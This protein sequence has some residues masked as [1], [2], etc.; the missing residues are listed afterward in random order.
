M[1]LEVIRLAINKENKERISISLKHETIKALR[2]IAE[3]NNR[4]VSGQIEQF[5]QMYIDKNKDA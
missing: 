5:V 2:E 3:K 1:Y 4:T